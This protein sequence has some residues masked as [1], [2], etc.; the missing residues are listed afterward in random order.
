MKTVGWIPF[1]IILCVSLGLFRG[2]FVA[3]ST[4]QIDELVRTSHIVF[5]GKV[6]RLHA[7]NL[8]ALR[9]TDSMVLVRV[10]E[11]LDAPPSVASLKGEEV[12]VQVARTGEIE[13]NSTEVF[14][15]N[16]LL[17]GEHLAVKEVGHIPAPTDTAQLQKEISAVR[18]QMD[19]EKL[20]LRLN[21]ATLVI[22]GKVLEVKPLGRTGLR[23]EHEPD[24]A[25]AVVEIEAVEKGSWKDRT[26]PVVFP[27]SMDERWLLSPK[28]TRGETGIWFLRHEEHVG[29]PADNWFALSALDFHPLEQREFIRRLLR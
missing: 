27:Q 15:S 16:G 12:T 28:F 19:E 1:T 7:T 8:K 29:L 2:E 21:G 11:V 6:A 22:T 20:K 9:P 5:V 10:I 14:F 23:S 3:Q 25:E 4:G 17:F 13:Q 26:V 18:A 24:W